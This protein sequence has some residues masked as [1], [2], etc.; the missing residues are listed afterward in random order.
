MNIRI[1]FDTGA[2]RSILTTGAA[3]RAGVKSGAPGVTWAGYSG[4]RS[5]ESWIGPFSSFS[6]GDEAV[7]NTRLRFGAIQLDHADMLLGADFFLSHRIYVS[8]SQHKLYF[9]YNGGPVFNLAQAAD[10]E[11]G[12]EPPA[13]Q[14]PPASAAPTASAAADE[15]GQVPQDAAGFARR[16]AAYAARR[17]FSHAIADLGR[18]VD[19]DPAN[20][21]YPYQRAVAEIAVHQTKPAMADLDRALKLKPDDSKALMERGRLR[22]TE[23]DEPGA[24]ADFDAAARIDPTLGLQI[25]NTYTYGGAFEDAI[26]TYDAWIGAH[27]KDPGRPTWLNDRCWSRALWGQEL[28]RA[29]IDCDAA[30]KASPRVPAY[31]DSRGLVHL[32]LGQFDDAIADY[33]AVLK[34]QPKLAWSLYGRG[35][36]KLRLGKTADGQADINA[37]IALEPKLP[38]EAKRFGVAP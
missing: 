32:R 6:V 8:K 31:R 10:A 35:L 20:P 38:D 4:G 23:K 36:A 15:G 3:A 33:D 7:K 17:D 22:L 2:P 11:P 14:A 5:V 27:P 1:V 16:G 29:L 13:A 25:A 21:A 9:T 19:L 37:A 18:A 12:N 26:A 34:A 30:I 28:D 24:K